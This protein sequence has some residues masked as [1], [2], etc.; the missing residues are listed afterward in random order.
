MSVDIDSDTLFY[1]EELEDT[2]PEIFEGLTLT[3][4]GENREAILIRP[5]HYEN[6]MMIVKKD[7]I[8]QLQQALIN[9][10]NTGYFDQEG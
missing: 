10:L 9:Y 2:P 5:Y 6:G 8:E 3:I 4:T 7:D 1:T